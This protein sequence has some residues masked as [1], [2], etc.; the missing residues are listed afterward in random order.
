MNMVYRKALHR[1]AGAGLALVLALYLPAAAYAAESTPEDSQEEPGSIPEVTQAPSPEG[2]PEVSSEEVP[3][4]SSEEIPGAASEEE[5]EVSQ[6]EPEAAPEEAP[7]ATSGELPE[8]VAE[9]TVEAYDRPEEY[10]VQSA[11]AGSAA[12]APAGDAVESSDEKTGAHTIH[13]GGTSFGAGDDETSHW[14]DGKGWKNVAGQYVAMVDYDGSGTE[15]SAE[16]GDLTLAVAGVNRIGALK[17]NCSINI[18]GTGIVLID[19]IEI[20]EGKTVSLMPDTSLYSEGSAAVF[21][22][23]GNGE[24][25]LLNGDIPAILDEEYTL[26]NISLRVP[27]DC[28]VTL[29]CVASW[30]EIWGPDGSDGPNSE[31]RRSATVSDPDPVHEGGQIS[32]IKKSAGKL[33]LGNGS[34]LTVDSGVLVS[35]RSIGT[36]LDNVVA[37][38]VVQGTLTL[39]GVIEGG[40]VEICDGGSLNGNGTV[41]SA[42]VTLDPSGSLS[43]DIHIE[44]SSLTVS[45]AGRSISTKID[46]SRL[47]LGPGIT[48]E[49]LS[50]SGYSLVAFDDG[51]EIG[52]ISLSEGS[53]LDL[54]VSGFL[55]DH[56]H[57]MLYDRILTISGEI[58]GGAVSVLSGCVRFTGETGILPS[59][60]EGYAS[61]VCVTGADAVSTGLPLIITEEDAAVWAEK[62]EIPVV[63][64]SVTDRTLPDNRGISIWIVNSAK[65]LDPLTREED[66]SFTCASFLERYGLTEDVFEKEPGLEV[67]LYSQSRG[68]E[69]L[70]LWMDDT[71]SF[72]TEDVCMIRVLDASSRW[73]QGGSAATHTDTSFTGSGVLGGSGAGSVQAGSGKVIFGMSVPAGP[74]PDD[75]GDGKDNTGTQKDRTG[76]AVKPSRGDR[77]T[78]ADPAVGAD[79]LTVTVSLRED[80]DGQSSELSADLPQIY[81]LSVTKDGVPVFDLAGTT[82]KVIFPFAVPA[83]WGEPGTITEGTLYAVFADEEGVLTAYAAEYDPVTG[84][85]SFESEQT[86]DFVIVRSA[87]KEE[88][89]T[90]EFYRA[91]EELE[92]VREF[93]VTL[94]ED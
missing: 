31:I 42:D 12:S 13:I 22:N 51:D 94:R 17:G 55:E 46:N 74:D 89:F 61:R 32:D 65:D 4:A 75:N 57:P 62:E 6:E 43:E 59:V 83:A 10:S 26:E 68:F 1:L 44:N 67:L 8:P 81:T 52:N 77:R 23:Q 78:A 18:V 79:G 66:Q 64:L 25:L 88:P 36:A 87:Y 5:P 20:E 93:L 33:V 85:I 63:M 53:R 50:V 91:L 58:S 7:E 56:S 72:S 49:E 92:E 38:L 9:E 40:F 30:T 54:C 80:R 14:S 90:E 29:G 15:I 60:P 71:A 2:A 84:E 35:L 28:S 11:A 82:V 24:Y 73:E 27:G 48:V 16:G 39:D 34:T 45:G 70:L 41:R 47:F 21:L 86:G 19:R 69:R 3:E 37:D 76:R